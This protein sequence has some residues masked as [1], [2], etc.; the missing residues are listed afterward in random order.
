MFSKCLGE[1]KCQVSLY[2]SIYLYLFK[3]NKNEFFKM[4]V[5]ISLMYILFFF[6]SF[7]LIISYIFKK[8]CFVGGGDV[9]SGTLDRTMHTTGMFC[10]STDG[11]EEL[12]QEEMTDEEDNDDDNKKASVSEK[13]NVTT[14]QKLS[15][16]SKSMNN[17]SGGGGGGGGTS[18]SEKV[19]ESDKDIKI[20]ESN[21]LLGSSKASFRDPNKIRAREAIKAVLSC[22]LYIWTVSTGAIMQGAVCFILYFITQVLKVGWEIERERHV[23]VNLYCTMYMCSI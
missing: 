2:L 7:F 9:A 15:Q 3:C 14:Y 6:F 20:S 5:D 23:L 11:Y 18:S 4:Y 12:E 21:S 22:P 16:V 17:K 10:C 8:S 1:R 13:G 19:V